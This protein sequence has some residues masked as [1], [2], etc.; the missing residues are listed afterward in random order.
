MTPG[1]V[2]I[3]DFLTDGSLIRL[4][5]SAQELTGLP[6]TLR[7]GRG[8]VVVRGDGERVYALLT[9]GDNEPTPAPEFAAPLVVDD[10]AIGSIALEWTAAAPDPALRPAV[11]TF[12]TH[13][14]ATVAE[15]CRGQVDLRRRVEELGVLYRLSSMLVGATTVDAVLDAAL[16]AAVQTLGA[17]AGSIRI[18]DDEHRVLQL[19]ASVG[20]S[21]GYISA[22]G[23]LPAS[24]ACDAEALGGAVIITPDI[25]DRDDFLHRDSL[26]AEGLLGMASVGLVFRGETL[27]LLR[28]YSRETMR[29]T[30]EEQDLLQSIAQ[31][32]AAGVANARLL[33][34]EADARRVRRQLAL[35]SDVQRRMLPD[36][37]PDA[38]GIDLAARFDPCFELGG[39][40][41]DAFEHDG[42]LALALGDVVG[43]GVP[44]ALLM[45]AVRA[46]IRAHTYN[47]ANVDEVM[48]GANQALCRDTLINEFATLFLGVIN[49]ATR[50]LAYCNAGHE[51]P[52]VVRVPAHRPPTTADLDELPVG[53]MVLGVDPSQRYQQGVYDLHPGDVVL[54]YSDGLT[55]AMNF[56]ENRFGKRR[57]RDALLGILTLD[58]DAPADRIASHILWERR[59]YTGLARQTDDTTILVA[60][61]R[62]PNRRA[63]SK[64]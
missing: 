63:P 5:E 17:D 8:R 36:V 24:R 7:D 58:P 12:L 45:S 37:L 64:Q 41:Y 18:I 47:I 55:D 28:L 56:Q 60:R 42:L 40:F 29:A 23:A 21:H 22:A 26:D 49:P 62:E 1:G 48:A 32:I 25:H 51:P 27:G 10:R 38:P 19:R 3:T 20:L 52:V 39:D 30:R 31:Q 14:A 4:C 44:A 2:C 6:V 61:V 11:E 33:E 35:A 54:I 53:G 15:V 13:L 34:A 9:V 57:V 43:K 46:T 16:H 59:R 50:R